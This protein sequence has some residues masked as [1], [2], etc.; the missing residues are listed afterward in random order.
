VP[1][2]SYAPCGDLSLAYQTGFEER[3][4]VELRGVPGEWELLTVDR[5]GAQAGS[6]EA[7]LASAPTPGARSTMRRSDRAV[8]V[9]AKRTPWILRGMSRI[10]P[11][12]KPASHDA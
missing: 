8:A 10:A 7:K 9:M 3:G 4:V 5:D 12:A 6:A 2:T 11:A 1:E